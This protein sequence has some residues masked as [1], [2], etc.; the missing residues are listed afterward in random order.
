MM[1]K[2]AF[3]L[4]SIR[5]KKIGSKVVILSHGYLSDKNSRTNLALENSLNNAG[6]STICYDLF[7]HGESEGDLEYLNISNALES[8]LSIC[9]YA[10]SYKEIALIGSS[11]SGSI[12]LIAASEINPKVI[13]L[14]CPVYMPQDLFINQLGENGIK[15]WK[16]QG[17]NEF[18]GRKWYYGVFEDS[19]KFDMKQIVSEI[20]SPI[21]VVHGSNDITVPISQAEDLIYHIRSKEKKLVEIKNEDHYFKKNFSTMIDL[22]SDWVIIHLDS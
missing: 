3:G 6:V 12:S 21:L 19:K 14:K 9:K 4:V 5:E 11:F 10:E 8:L 1:I 18:F 16:K 22:I 2:S 20:T 13:A 15:K 7:G 17:F